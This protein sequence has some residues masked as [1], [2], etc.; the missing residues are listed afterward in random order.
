MMLNRIIKRDQKG[1]AFL[2]IALL[3]AG[4]LSFSARLLAQDDERLMMLLA[5]NCLQCH[6]RPET[7]APLIGAAEDWQKIVSK[8]EEGMLLNVVQGIAGMPPLGYCSACS[9]QDFRALIR[10]IT[11][12]SNGEGH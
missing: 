5:N 9:E 10:L 1:T 2:L 7:G 4:S 6:A 12:T 11:G 3:W 8:G